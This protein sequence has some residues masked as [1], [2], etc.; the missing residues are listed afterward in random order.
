MSWVMA[1]L[2]GDRSFTQRLSWGQALGTPG[3]GFRATLMREGRVL[4]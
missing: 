1:A 2:A 3:M 4:S